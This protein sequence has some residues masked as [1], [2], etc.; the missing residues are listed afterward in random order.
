M[1]RVG[2]IG[3]FDPRAVTHVATNQTLRHAADALGEERHVQWVATDTIAG[4]E[5]LHGFSA[6]IIAPGSPYHSQQGALG[7]S[8]S[9]APPA[10][11]FSAG[12]RRTLRRFCSAAPSLSL[13]GHRWPSIATLT[14]RTPWKQLQA[15]K[16]PIGA[17]TTSATS[18]PRPH[19][20]SAIPRRCWPPTGHPVAAPN[21]LL[22]GRSREHCPRVVLRAAP[23]IRRMGGARR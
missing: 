17:R 9:P 21:D 14:S 11:L 8:A 16:W 18:A 7:Q 15:P 20:E 22:A 4:A 6:F 3:D 23:P 5:D 10:C 19:G 2:V 12:R 13:T 1:L